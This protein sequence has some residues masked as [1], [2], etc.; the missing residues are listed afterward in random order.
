M[1]ARSP[2]FALKVGL[3][4]LIGHAS[5]LSGRGGGTT[6]PGRAL[7]ELE[8]AALNRLGRRLPGPITVVSA[9]N[10]KTTTCSLVAGILETAGR[11]PVHNRA[12][13]NMAWGVATA[14]VSQNGEEG[15]FEVDE[16]WLPE[17]ADQLVPDVFVLANLFR[18]QLDR[19]GELDT[20]ADI[21]RRMITAHA[22]RPVVSHG[23]RAGVASFVLN[24]D[25]PRVADLARDAK[26]RSLANVIYFGVDDPAQ[27]ADGPG[28]ADDIAHCRRCGHAYEYELRLL[29]HLGHYSCP[30]CGLTRP[31]PHFSATLVEPRGMAGSRVEVSGPTGE[32]TVDLPLPG[33]YNV[34]NALAALA[35]A[36][37]LG[38][39]PTAAAAAMAGSEAAF[40]RVE[41]LS[42]KGRDVA[43]LLIKN[44]TGATEVLRTLE[45]SAGTEGS[46]SL[47]IALNDGIADGRDISWIWDTDFE[48]LADTVGRVT[49]SGTRAE[50]L[51]LRLSYAGWPRERI[52]IERDLAGSFD[53]ALAASEGTLYALP[54]YT[55]LLELR[56]ILN[57]R[58]QVSGYLG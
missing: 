18:D 22:Q 44:P 55:A 5:R 32:F 53:Q 21:W 39:E 35:G 57:R 36:F 3:A 29:G 2:V 45:P 50:E 10:G 6:L 52:S 23:G 13:S 30:E 8:P 16:A 43:I 56:S 27:A 25:D 12:G 17:V 7:L 42:I 14:L 26:G 19:H 49:C 58:G 41:R 51:A 38:V 31:T 11:R 28:I 20:L 37:A 47:W 48:R 9:T 54:T 24:A 34:Y 33:L 1:R 40:G 15:L 46:L 4:R